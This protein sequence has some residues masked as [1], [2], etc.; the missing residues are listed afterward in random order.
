MYSLALMS[1]ER[2]FPQLKPMTTRS[3]KDNLTIALSL[4]LINTSVNL[5]NI[6]EGEKTIQ[7]FYHING[8]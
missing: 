5:N 1:R 7:E 4:T 2:L 6:F 3:Q 8:K